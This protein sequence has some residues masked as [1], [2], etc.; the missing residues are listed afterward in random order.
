MPHLDRKDGDTFVDHDLQIMFRK[1][2]NQIGSDANE[3][4]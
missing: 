2:G 1:P 3:E 4:S